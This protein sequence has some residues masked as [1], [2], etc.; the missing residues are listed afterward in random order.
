MAEARTEPQRPLPEI[1]ELTAPFWQATREGR[2]VMQR[3]RACGELVWCPRPS[4]VECGGEELEWDELSGR[5]TVYSFTIIRQLAGRG[6]RAF[7]KDIPYVIAWVDLEEGPRYYTNI[8][9]GVRW[10]TWKSGW[11]WRRCSI[12][13]V[14]TSACPSSSPAEIV[15]VLP[16]QGAEGFRETDIG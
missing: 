14:T 10:T 4:C 11:R 13:S 8:V 3:C 6:A 5:G 7:E 1:T 12:R 16:A 9:P 2:L 15:L